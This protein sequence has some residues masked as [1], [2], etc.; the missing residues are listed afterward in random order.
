MTIHLDHYKVR[1]L[2]NESLYPLGRSDHI[3]KIN[4]K[5]DEH[6]LEEES[7]DDNDEWK[8]GCKVRK[9]IKKKSNTPHKPTKTKA[10]PRDNQGDPRRKWCPIPHCRYHRGKGLV[11]RWTHFKS[12]HIEFSHDSP[13]FE[14]IKKALEEDEAGK[15]SCVSCKKVV[16]FTDSQDRCLQCSPREEKTEVPQTKATKK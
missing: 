14:E 7:E 10:K 4:S 13:W 12:H 3:L 16:G 6:K 8:P 15:F 5:K 11:K 1:S 9:T 2:K